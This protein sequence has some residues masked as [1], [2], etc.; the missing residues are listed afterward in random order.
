[1]ISMSTRRII[2]V[3][4]LVTLHSSSLEKKLTCWGFYSKWLNFM[5]CNRFELMAYHL[6]ICTEWVLQHFAL[7]LGSVIGEGTLQPETNMFS[8]R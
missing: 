7:C 3:F 6:L 4:S 5:L 2:V 8:V 1:M